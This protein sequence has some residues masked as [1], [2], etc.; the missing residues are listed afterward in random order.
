MSI[1]SANAVLT[2]SIPLLFPFPQRI[3]GF[4]TDDIYDVPAIKKVETQMGVDGVLSAGFVYV[5]IPQDITLQADSISN[6]FFDTWA[7]QMNAAQDVYEASGEIVLPGISTKF[8]QIRGF[9]TGYTPVPAGKKTLQP[10]K[11]QITWQNIA[12]SPA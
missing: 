3:Q 9:L 4:A 5:E 1:T 10:R 8:Q 7:Q 12:P 11:Y 6:L 2:L